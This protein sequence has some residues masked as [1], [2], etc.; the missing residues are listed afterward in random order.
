MSYV[1]GLF[2]DKVHKFEKQYKRA[3]ENSTAAA[4]RKLSILDK[5]L[6]HNPLSE[7][8]LFRKLDIVSH[9]CDLDKVSRIY[10]MEDCRLNIDNLLTLW[11]FQVS[12]EIF[13]ILRQDFG[14]LGLW[15]RYIKITQCVISRCTV[16]KVTS[17]YAKAMEKVNFMQK[18]G[19]LTTELNLIGKLN[20]GKFFNSAAS[21]RFS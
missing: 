20:C 12:E 4:E 8:L 18:H 5:A 19:I 16:P 13:S 14:N 21:V 6:T 10:L 3:K 7:S 11:S 2:Q 17:L 9:V 1:E 15:N